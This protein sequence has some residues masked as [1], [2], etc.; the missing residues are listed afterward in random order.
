MTINFNM[1]G[2]WL[3]L[4]KSSVF[5]EKGMSASFIKDFYIDEQL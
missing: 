4:E 2:R 5:A 3:V 1:F